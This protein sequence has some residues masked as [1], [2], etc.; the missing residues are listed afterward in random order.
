MR[1]DF[2]GARRLYGQAQALQ[3]R[4]SSVAPADI[5][6]TLNGLGDY[7]AAQPDTRDSMRS[8]AG[9]LA[10]Q[11]RRAEGQALLERALAACE[12]ELGE[13]HPTT[14]RVLIPPRFL[15]TL[16]TVFW[17]NERGTVFPA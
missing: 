9:M 2:D 3:E 11:G 14:A 16:S 1:G 8:L 17:Y 12:R 5:A 10:Y 13:S 4:A 7:A 6:R 15:H